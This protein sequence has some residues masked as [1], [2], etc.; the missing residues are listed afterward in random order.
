MD[1]EF[2]NILNQETDAANCSLLRIGGI[3]ILLDLGCDES[4][5]NTFERVAQAARE[6]NYIFISNSDHKFIG[7]L[8]Y[9]YKWGLLS[10]ITIFGTSAVTK[11]GA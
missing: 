5:S 11:L 9:L 2:T 4:T 6:C 10:H 1:F 3:K 8:P 7:C